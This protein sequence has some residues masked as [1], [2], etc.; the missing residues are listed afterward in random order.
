MIYDIQNNSAA[1]KT[2]GYLQSSSASMSQSLERLSSGYRIN[3]ASDDA[4]G[5]A[6]SN[7]LTS[8]VAAANIAQ[9]NISQGTSLLQIADGAMSTVSD[10]LTRMNELATEASSAGADVTPLSNEYQTL[11]SEINRIANSTQ[12]NGTNLLNGTFG[13]DN[14][15]SSSIATGANIYNVN[16]AAAATGSYAVTFTGGVLTIENPSDTVSQSVTLGAGAQTYNFSELGISFQTTAAATTTAVAASIGAA[17]VVAA[18]G[19]PSETFQIGYTNNTNSQ[20]SVSLNSITAASLGLSATAW[21]S[22]SDAQTAMTDIAGA[23]NNLST[24]QAANGAYENRLNYASENLTTTVQNLT[25]ANSAIKDVDMAS[26]MTNYT[27]E[28]ILVQAGTAM[29]AQANTAPQQ[30]LALFK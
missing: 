23:I 4:S 18:G 24:S 8:D 2:E 30:V 15:T 26:E 14:T 20:L 13:S 21:A 10:I 17:I 28:Q 9:Q 1:L 7:S 12:Y 29:L 19:S 27:K 6:I 25:S 11:Y 22:A 16:V 5:L 3:S